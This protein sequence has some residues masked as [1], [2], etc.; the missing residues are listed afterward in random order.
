MSPTPVTL[1]GATGMVGQRLIELLEDHPWFTAGVL[2]AS[3]RSAGRRYAEACDWHLP[4]E[5][6]GSVGDT[7]VVPTTAAAIHAANGGP[8]IA[9]SALPRSVA[10]AVERPLM[11][12][13]WTVISNASAHRMDADVPLIIPEINADHLALCERQ[14][15]PGRLVTNGNCTSM[16]LALALAPLHE[17]V[18]I[19][20]VC[21]ASYQAVSGAGYP[22]ESAWDL[23]GNVRPHPGDEEEKMAEEPRKFLG[24]LTD[25]GIELA[26][27]AMSA[28][29]VRVPV[30][31][32][33]LVAAQIKTKQPLSPA[34][35]KELLRTWKPRGPQLP[36]SPAQVLRL[37]ER[38]DRPQPRFDSHHGGGMSVTIGRVEHCPV[39]GLKLFC[40]THNT[41]RGAAGAALL[42]A[43]LVHATSQG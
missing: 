5:P 38:L 12:L 2:A 21:A 35:A 9:L 1:L 13:G 15:G 17:A 31:D 16:P 36:S 34:D 19:E 39:M 8:G 42:N 23:I 3:E 43:E 32:G 28:R 41:I 25:T 18:G 24:T 22:G 6:H 4:S 30:I 14:E 11:A 27:F 33:H 20:A 37:D 29:C 40:M 26:D 10:H 7:L